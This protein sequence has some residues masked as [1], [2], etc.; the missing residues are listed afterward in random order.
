MRE[1]I[2]LE[3]LESDS[4]KA[5]ENVGGKKMIANTKFLSLFLERVQYLQE[6]RLKAS[7]YLCFKLKNL[8]QIVLIECSVFSR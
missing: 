2:L 3:N 5:R 4:W 6:E 1:S 8:A 7:A